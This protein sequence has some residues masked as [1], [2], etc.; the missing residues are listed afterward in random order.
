MIPVN[1]DG[2]SSGVHIPQ[3]SEVPTRLTWKAVTSENA[4]AFVC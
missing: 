2:E 4:H 1:D 3:S